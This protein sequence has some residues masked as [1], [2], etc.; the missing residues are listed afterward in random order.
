VPEQTQRP[1]P[2]PGRK[3]ASKDAARR[4]ADNDRAAKREK[5]Q[6][7]LKALKQDQKRD[8][9]RVNRIVLGFGGLALVAMITLSL[10]LPWPA[11]GLLALIVAAVLAIRGIRLAR[12]TPLAGGAVMYLALGLGLLGMFSLYSIPLVT[13]WGEQWEYQ[14][15]VAQTQTIEGRDDCFAAYEKATEADWR[16]ILQRGR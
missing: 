15:C 11:A 13:T 12:R 10:P 9:L 1:K 6:Q 16:Q 14:Q 4:R 7:E 8:L 2:S 5:L 3:R